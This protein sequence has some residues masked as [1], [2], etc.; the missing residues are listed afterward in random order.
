MANDS[1]ITLDLGRLDY[2]SRISSP[3]PT[4]SITSLS[5]GPKLGLEVH[6]SGFRPALHECKAEEDGTIKHLRGELFWQWCWHMVR[7][8]HHWVRQGRHQARRD[9]SSFTTIQPLGGLMFTYVGR[10]SWAP[11]R[12]SPASLSSSIFVSAG[13]RHFRHCNWD[14]S[15]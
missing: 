7:E 9:G 12:F 11:L 6:W 8:G 5:A 1:D 10:H 3:A 13:T 4:T 14:S 15:G 2:S